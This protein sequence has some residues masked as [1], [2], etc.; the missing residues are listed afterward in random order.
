MSLK[1]TDITPLL[2]PSSLDPAVGRQVVTLGRMLADPAVDAAGI[3]RA[4]AEL[5]TI[6]GHL[7]GAAGIELLSAEHIFFSPLSEPPWAVRGL[8]LCPGRPCCFGGYGASGKTLAAQALALSCALGRAVWGQFCPR[9][10][11]VVRHVD[12]EQGDSATRWRYRRLARGMGVPEEELRDVAAHA[13]LSFAPFP[14][15]YLTSANALDAFMRAAEGADLLIVDALRGATP[16]EDE[17]DSTMRAYLDLLSRV[18]SATGC[19]II[20]LHHAKKG[21]G[22]TNAAQLLRG[23]GAIYDGSGAIFMISAEKQDDP[24][25]VEQT[26]ASQDARGRM[27]APFYLAIEDVEVDGDPTGGLRVSYRTEEQIKPP[28]TPEERFAAVA[29]EVLCAVE[30]NP[31]SGARK[32]RSLVGRA[33]PAVDAALEDLQQCGRVRCEKHGKR[34]AYF[35]VPRGAAG[36]G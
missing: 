16:G 9:E 15:V 6:T 27:I 32:V 25:R 4:S 20:V 1:E 8:Q 18:S 17:N 28:L 30:R 33:A 34:F 35:A 19:T 21:D 23:S 22:K 5:Q 12:Y 13:R 3:K 36:G 24:K 7:V 29:S 26:R 10:A 11:M 2:A 14:P 31:G